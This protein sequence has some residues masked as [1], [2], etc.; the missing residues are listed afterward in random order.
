MAPG[1]AGGAADPC[2][3]SRRHPVLRRQTSRRG[4]RRESP[5][6]PLPPSTPWQDTRSPGRYASTIETIASLTTLF[7]AYAAGRGAEIPF[8]AMATAPA[9]VIESR[10]KEVIADADATIIESEA[11]P[12]AGSVPGRSIPTPAIRLG[13]NPEPVW[14]S[15]ADH[16]P[17]VIASRR[18]GAVVVNLRSVAPSRRPYRGRRS[19]H[20]LMPIVGTAGHVDHGKS[21]LVEALTGR[22]PDRWAA[23]KE[24]GADDRS[25]LRLGRPRRRARRRVRRR[26]GP[27]TVRKEHARRRRRF[28]HCPFR[29]GG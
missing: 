2:R 20:P 13:G 18:D 22:D 8:W 23:E 10:S 12:G 28:R 6:A 4:R 21:T 9:D 5:S 27:R 25:R 17:P 15:L 24:R 3:R 16:Q 19:G 7:E 29:R 11:L 26:A 1:R 14:R